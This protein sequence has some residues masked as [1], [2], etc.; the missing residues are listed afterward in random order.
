LKVVPVIVFIKK[1][2]LSCICVIIIVIDQ[3]KY[4]CNINTK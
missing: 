3:T 2:L 4:L 1:I